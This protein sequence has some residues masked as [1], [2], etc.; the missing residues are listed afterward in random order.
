MSSEIDL[1]SLWQQQDTGPA[2]NMQEV[3]SGAGK[4][5]KNLRKK[6]LSLNI[7]LG[8]TTL[9]IC[10]VAFYYD[11]KMWTTITG[12]IFILLAI[13]SYLAVTN[14]SLAGLFK[15]NPSLD[16]QAYLTNLL[17]IQ[18]KQRYLQR[19]LLTAYFI[20]LSAGLALYMIE[21]VLKM[22][23]VYGIIAYTCVTIW[24]AFNWWYIRPRTIR[25]Q[26]KELS[27]MIENL[28]AINVQVTTPDNMES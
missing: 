11:Y 7:M 6:L 22:K 1:K 10:V 15:D 17:I 27:R 4:L 3:L 23:I 19:T 25:K 26:Q 18:K 12:I 2:A 16:N 13:I 5:K 24:I 21:S 8:G 28:Q 20:L 9:F 14:F